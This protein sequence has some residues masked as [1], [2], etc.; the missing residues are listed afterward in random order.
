MKKSHTNG[1]FKSFETVMCP[2]CFKEFKHALTKGNHGAR[3]GI[4]GMNCKKCSKEC[5]KLNTDFLKRKK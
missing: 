1:N 5:S 3:Y 4:R 2:V